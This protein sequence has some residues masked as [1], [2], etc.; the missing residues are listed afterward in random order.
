M[1]KF[2]AL[3]LNTIYYKIVL[4]LFYTREINKYGFNR[5]SKCKI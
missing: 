2:W 4:I 5:C 1:D 3:A